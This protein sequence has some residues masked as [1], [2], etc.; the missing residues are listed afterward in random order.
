VPLFY[1]GQ[2]DKDVKP[3][4]KRVKAYGKEMFLEFT[5]V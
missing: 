5:L 2:I 4:R 1:Q 3:E